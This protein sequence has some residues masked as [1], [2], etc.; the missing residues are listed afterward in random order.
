MRATCAGWSKADVRIKKC[1]PVAL[2]FAGARVIDFHRLLFLAAVVFV[3]VERHMV[4]VSDP[5]FFARLRFHSRDGL[6][7]ARVSDCLGRGI[8]RAF[9]QLDAGAH[10]VDP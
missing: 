2:F 4:V 5:N 10:V 9:G 6:L 1:E 7:F 8:I 3:E